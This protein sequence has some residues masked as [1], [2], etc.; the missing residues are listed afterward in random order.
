MTDTDDT[1]VEQNILKISILK[2]LNLDKL[3]IKISMHIF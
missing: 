3:T 1:T 2:E